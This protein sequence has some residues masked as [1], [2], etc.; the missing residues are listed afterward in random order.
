MAESRT[1]GVFG[2][3]W[4]G[5]VTGGC[6]AELGHEVIVRDV[7]PERI[8][9]LQAGRLPFHEADLPEVL[10]RNRERIRYTLDADELA[11][12]DA[13][14]ICVQTP[15]TY[16]GDADLSFVWSALDDL[17]QVERRQILVMKSTVPVG[18]GEK[19]RAALEGRGLTNVG[20]VS[21]PEFLAEGHAVRDFLNPDRIV[22]GAFAEEDGVAVEALYGGIEA[23]VVRT[24]VASAEMIKLAANAFLMTRISFINEIANVCEAVG[25]DVVEVAK[26]VGLDHRLGPHFLRAGIGYGGSCL[27]GDET[28]LVRLDGEV[29]LVQ[30]ERLYAELEDHA[31]LE[32]LAWDP[33]GGSVEF[34]AVTAMTRREVDGE[35]IE[36]RTKMGRRIRC[37]PDH[38]WVT[39]E[40]VKLAE[41]LTEQDWLPIAAST[42][43][44]TRPHVWNLLEG[45]DTAGLERE[46]VIV[47]PA[48]LR[49]EALGAKRLQVDI[50]HRRGAVARW[51]DILRSGALR[52]NELD[53]TEL[54]LERAQLGSCR[55]GTYVPASI[56]EDED[57]WR[58]VG[59][60][61]A[62]GH[63]T[64]DGK[65]RRLQWSFHP[66]DEF[67]LVEEVYSFWAAQRVRA[68]VRHL[69]T[70]TAVS[71]SSRILAGFWLGS[72]GLGA[73]CYEQ[74][75][76]DSI[77]T[78]PAAYQRAAL[79]GMWRGD[80]SWSFVNGGPGVILE[81]GTVSRELADGVLRLLAGFGIV[82]SVRVGRAAK[83]TCDTFWIRISGAQQ[84]EQLLDFVPEQ[85]RPVISSSIARQARRIAPTGYHRDDE[86]VWVRVVD[87]IRRPFTGAVYS[88][89]VPGPHTFVT[90]GGLVTH[91]CFPKDSLALKQLASNS[92]YHFQLLS[93]VI[94]VNELQKRR[95]VQKLQKHLGKL[96]GKKIA[97]L[98][99]A[100]KADTDDMRE[101]PSLVLA[102]RLLAE[103]AEVRAWDPVARP[104][105]LMKG[106]VLCDS[107]LEAVRGADAAVIV[108]EW[109]E[110]RGVAS[111]DV[112][113][114]MARPLIL[115][116]RNLLDPAETRAA[117][118][119]YE[120]I[121]R[122][123]S[124]FEAL[125][126]TTEPQTTVSS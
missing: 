104:G 88:L 23:P 41:Q 18:T 2:A 126:E 75:L 49:L 103:G 95:V 98:G 76:P 17:P 50:D 73:N 56:A 67:D 96:R 31:E 84:V 122:P 62:E 54:S 82:A 61:I 1:I 93:A 70:T 5:L 30:L 109:D 46:D 10:D 86:T 97:L 63:C 43:A 120:G 78:A 59:L 57:F 29:R 89:E 45:L 19:V 16:S 123:S 85:D 35:I 121:G 6:F 20:Y 66:R 60:Y 39:R 99:L 26:G 117:G 118:F 65:R 52:L 79:A 15:P 80:G 81:Y 125:P 119:A 71:V 24:D 51:H 74:R 111:K 37:T 21:N 32:A 53:Q 69:S 40:G 124:P 112:H 48:P 25:A 64:A 38:P 28:A 110:L 13:L 14:F 100:F 9:A 47:R 33:E 92:G 55:N 115:D 108:T 12:A 7:M 105:E 91:N 116:G 8:E 68:S 87:K 11:D 101:A 36:L 27:T 114:A 3:G 22:I 44:T 34:A 58:I 72:L 107:V 42:L 106:A 102:S 4:V 77:W 113:D 90:T 83:S 94:E